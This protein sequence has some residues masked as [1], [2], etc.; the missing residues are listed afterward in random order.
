MRRTITSAVLGLLCASA[1]TGTSLAQ[2][3]AKAPWPSTRM[4]VRRDG[5][6]DLEH[7]RE[8]NVNH[9]LRA[10]K[11]LA[12][13][14][15]ICRPGPRQ[16]YPVRFEGADP[17]CGAMWLTSYPP[18]KLLSFRLD[19]VQYIALVTIT[20]LRGKVLKIAHTKR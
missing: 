17:Q 8:T 12:A 9:Y 2:V 14:N 7:L 6:A 15:E 20:N 18:K 19:H 11:I 4:S 5:P 1:L 10:K 16:P 13:A 3:T